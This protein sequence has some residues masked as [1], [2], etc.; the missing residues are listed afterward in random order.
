MTTPRVHKLYYNAKGEPFFIYQ[1][2]RHYLQD[3]VRDYQDPSVLFL[4]TCN[5]GGICIRI[6]DGADSVEVW[7]DYGE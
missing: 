4:T 6:T 7:E 5:F 3:F 1:G 2:R